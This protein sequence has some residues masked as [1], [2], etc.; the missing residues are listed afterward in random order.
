MSKRID[1][2]VSDELHASLRTAA[3]EH[4]RSLHSEVIW[5]LRATEGGPAVAY[6]APQHGLGEGEPSA[7]ETA[8]RAA[9][10]PAPSPSPSPGD[11]SV[12][13]DGEGAHG[14]EEDGPTSA[15]PP[16]MPDPPSRTKMCEHRVPAD[17]YCKKCAK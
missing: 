8:D 7:E 10:L 4:G 15:D 17:Q 16:P 11:K 2:R 12:G 6:W 5:R 14:G 13:Y 9:A 3:H 1:L